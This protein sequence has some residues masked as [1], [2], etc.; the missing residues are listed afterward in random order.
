MNAY[1]KYFGTL[2]KAIE[3]CYQSGCPSKCGLIDELATRGVCKSRT[4][5][6]CKECWK[7]AL[8]QEVKE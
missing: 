7:Q 2:E 3:T 5:D 1:E 4:F 6:E 8:N